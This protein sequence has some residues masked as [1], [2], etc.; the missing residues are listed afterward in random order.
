MSEQ[1]CDET[2][3]FLE[4]LSHQDVEKD[5][6]KDQDNLNRCENNFVP[7]KLRGNLYFKKLE[8]VSL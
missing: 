1:E 3:P 2:G 6:E 5:G 8:I 7:L 4:I